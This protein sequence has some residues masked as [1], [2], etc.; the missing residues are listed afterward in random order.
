[1]YIAP[2]TGVIDVSQD[3]AT[4]APEQYGLEVFPLIPW[5]CADQEKGSID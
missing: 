2:T 3:W 4:A 5:R 1:M